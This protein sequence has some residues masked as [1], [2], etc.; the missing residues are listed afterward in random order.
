MHRNDGVWLE[1][2]ETAEFLDNLNHVNFLLIHTVG[3]NQKWKWVVLALHNL[4]ESIFICHLRGIETTNLLVVDKNVQKKVL[5]K[6]NEIEDDTPWPVEKLARM[7]ELYSRVKDQS[8]LTKEFSLSTNNS[9]DNSINYINYIRNIFDHFLPSGQSID[10]SCLPSITRDC[11]EIIEQ[12]AINKIPLYSR[13]T[14]H[15]E[16]ISSLLLSIKNQL[17]KTE[18]HWKNVKDVNLK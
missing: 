8:L 14:E 3:N 4:M 5:V 17:K 6:M 7:T 13:L 2:D 18:D 15:T 16:I 12:L 10:I 1:T 11:C 9:Y